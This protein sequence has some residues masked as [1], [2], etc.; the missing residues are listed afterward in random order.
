MLPHDHFGGLTLKA[1]CLGSEGAGETVRQAWPWI[2]EHVL[3][4]TF[5]LCLWAS[6]VPAAGDLRCSLPRAKLPGTA[7]G[8]R[9]FI[10]LGSEA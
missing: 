1:N 3:T 9:S 2:C 5:S 6:P 4:F 7:G 8:K 10:L